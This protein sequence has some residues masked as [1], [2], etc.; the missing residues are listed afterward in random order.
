[1]VISNILNI[2]KNKLHN[3]ES[4][5]DRLKEA[6]DIDKD[7]E[8]AEFFGIAQNTISAWKKRD[9]M[10]FDLLFTRCLPLD[11][12]LNWLIYGK[13]ITSFQ[14]KEK[15]LSQSIHE[16]YRETQSELNQQDQVIQ[17]IEM[18]RQLPWPVSTRRVI[19]ENYL[20]LVYNEHKER[21][22]RKK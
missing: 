12:D 11:I 21:H 17:I 19:M 1:M 22:K 18:I 16:E 4:I 9:S 10:N 20:Y 5:L 8:L 2:N 6:L 14:K 3:I 13:S 15:S 7:I